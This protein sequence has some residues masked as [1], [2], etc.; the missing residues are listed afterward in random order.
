MVAGAGLCLLPF[1]A[2]SQVPS[3][4]EILDALDTARFHNY[5]I[6]AN[7][8]SYNAQ[9]SAWKTVAC[10]HISID[11]VVD[12]QALNVLIYDQHLLT[13]DLYKLLTEQPLQFLEVH[14]RGNKAHI[15]KA[16]FY[17]AHL[18]YDILNSDY[19]LGLDLQNPLP[20]PQWG[21]YRATIKGGFYPM[22]SLPIAIKRLP[23]Q[24]GKALWIISA[25]IFLERN[26]N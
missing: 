6:Y 23:D 15:Y 2:F 21:W 12:Q 19:V 22:G 13:D 25:A 3:E 10:N 26:Y 4:S 20:N 7:H 1:L 16:L 11:I 9:W 17:P 24:G 14:K 8:G 5:D 18:K